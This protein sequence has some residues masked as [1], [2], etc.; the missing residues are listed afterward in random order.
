MIFKI[1]HL[2]TLRI[3]VILS[4]LVPAF[5]ISTVFFAVAI[6]KVTTLKNGVVF[7]SDIAK[8]VNYKYSMFFAAWTALATL[9][10]L[11]VVLTIGAFLVNQ[12][13]VVDSRT[14]VAA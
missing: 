7:I 14:P 10:P 6:G 4:I 5:W 2:L 12:V 1:K 9:H 8:D 13:T 11:I 3:L